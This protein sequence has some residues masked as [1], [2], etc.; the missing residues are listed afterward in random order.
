MLSKRTNVLFDE[1]T[2]SY[3]AFLA[4]RDGSS[5]GNLIRTAV[6]KV[7]F[8]DNEN[9]KRMKALENILKLRKNIKPVKYSE[10]K[11]WINYGR[12]Y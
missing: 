6:F 7:Y 9:Q 3:L 5:I 4:R 11:K 12:K 2:F 1:N 8:R 10:I